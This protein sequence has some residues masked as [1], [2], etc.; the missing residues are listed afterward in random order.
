M[1]L[2]NRRNGKIDE[3]IYFPQTSFV[4]L[5]FSFFGTFDQGDER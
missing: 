1:I 3:K 2:V 4:S 5:L